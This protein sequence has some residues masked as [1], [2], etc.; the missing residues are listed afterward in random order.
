MTE[1]QREYQEHYSPDGEYI[2]YLMEH[3]EINSMNTKEQDWEN[4]QIK[5]LKDVQEEYA[6][7][8]SEWNGK[9]PGI[10]EER[11][12]FANDIYDKC[13][14]LIELLQEFDNFD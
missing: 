9:S 7:I 14:E 12:Q 6:Q 3:P 10:K 13:Q 8:S 11:A 1:E 5:F 2:E 4:K